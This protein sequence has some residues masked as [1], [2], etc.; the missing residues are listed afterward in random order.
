M[1]SLAFHLLTVLVNVPFVELHCF[2]HWWQVVCFL[3]MRVV[4]T[5]EQP[6]CS[7]LC[8]FGK[9][10][11]SWLFGRCLHWLMLWFWAVNREQFWLEAFVVWNASQFDIDCVVLLF[12]VIVVVFLLCFLLVL[13][14][15]H[16][17]QQLW[18]WHSRQLFALCLDV[19][20]SSV[21]WILAL[22]LFTRI[23]RFYWHLLNQHLQ[24]VM[25][26]FLDISVVSKCLAHQSHRFAC[27]VNSGVLRCLDNS[28]LLED[29]F[30]FLKEIAGERNVLFE[31]H[32]GMGMQFYSPFWRYWAYTLV[33]VLIDTSWMSVKMFW[34]A[35]QSLY[36]I[37]LFAWCQLANFIHQIFLL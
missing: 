2:V 19:A 23:A 1:N 20:Q 13:Y 28:H 10:R 33:H 8:S 26:H 15:Q 3:T 37:K 9:W 32:H 35:L 24:L 29:I 14:D 16:S 6:V 36:E 7:W 11:V 25:S 21:Q 18:K 34:K 31:T 12:A 22:F 5:L 27:S 4:V 30:A 17:G